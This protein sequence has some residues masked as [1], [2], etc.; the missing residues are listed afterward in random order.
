MVGLELDRNSKR[1]DLYWFGSFDFRPYRKKQRVRESN[2][3]FYQYAETKYLVGLGAGYQKDLIED[4][5]GLYLQTSVNWSWAGYSGT[6]LKPP[7]GF[8]LVPDGGIY[9]AVG[10]YSSLQI[11]YTHQS[12]PLEIRG[13]ADE[14]SGRILVKLKLDL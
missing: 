6:N 1:T 9:I 5:F 10:P 8:M 13:V 2:S 7:S 3:I 12:Y 11:G 14:S 4:K